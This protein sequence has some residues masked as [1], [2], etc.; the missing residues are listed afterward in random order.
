MKIVLLEVKVRLVFN[1]INIV[2]LFEDNIVV[3][4]FGI[5]IV[6]LFIVIDM[7]LRLIFLL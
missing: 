5:L 6:V 7:L 2:F 3:V 1:L 4:V